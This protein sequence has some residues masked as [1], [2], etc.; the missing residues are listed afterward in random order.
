MNLCCS[1][2][3]FCNCFSYNT[4]LYFDVFINTKNIFRI[5]EIHTYTNRNFKNCITIYTVKQIT[6]EILH[7]NDACN[8]NSH[9]PQLS[10]YKISNYILSANNLLTV[11]DISDK[12][13]VIITKLDLNFPTHIIYKLCF[14]HSSAFIGKNI[15]K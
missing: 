4:S 12:H 11:R 10:N 8:T 2:K 3:Y 14:F 7:R 1:S 5:F 13:I 15:H 6:I 9:V